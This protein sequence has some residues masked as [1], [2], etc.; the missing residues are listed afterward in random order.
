MSQL[1]YWSL[2]IGGP[3]FPRDFC[4]LAFHHYTDIRELSGPEIFYMGFGDSN[5]NSQPSSES[6]LST[7][8]CL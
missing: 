5:S 4:V 8:P 3:S 6:N 7:E 1:R 2:C